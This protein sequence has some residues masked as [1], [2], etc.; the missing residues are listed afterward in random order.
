MDTSIVYE[1]ATHYV[2]RVA[3]GYEVY[4]ND[5]V[6]AV[7]VASIG[8]GPAPRLGFTRAKAEADRRTAQP[9]G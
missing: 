4:R 7:R 6:A 3:R 5:G 9:K 8:D 2:I 1:T